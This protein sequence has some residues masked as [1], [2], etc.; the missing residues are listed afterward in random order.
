MKDVSNASVGPSLPPGVVVSVPGSADG[1]LRVSLAAP[2]GYDVERGRPLV[3]PLRVSAPSTNESIR[4]SS[5]GPWPAGA[6]LV[7]PVLP[8]CM[9]THGGKPPTRACRAGD[10]VKI[11]PGSVID[12]P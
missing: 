9:V 1:E 2:E 3:N 6:K 10:V 11:E 5:A 7:V 12:L 8:D 4:T